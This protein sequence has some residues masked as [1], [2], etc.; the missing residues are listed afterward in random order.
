MQEKNGKFAPFGLFFFSFILS[1]RVQTMIISLK[2]YSFFL[3][4]S[5]KSSNFAA[6][7]EI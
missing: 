3:H 4:M 7:F 2:K 6:D 1:V 5:K